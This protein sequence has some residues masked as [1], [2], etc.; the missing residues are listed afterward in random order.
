MITN[1]SN[2]DQTY[3]YGRVVSQSSSGGIFKLFFLLF[4]VVGF[5]LAT[6][7]TASEFLA[8]RVYQAGGGVILV[9]PLKKTSWQD[10]GVVPEPEVILPVKTLGGYVDQPFLFDSGAVISSLPREFAEKTG[11]D[12]AFLPRSTFKGFGGTTSFA[13]RGEMNLLLGEK[14]ATFPVVFTEAMGTKSLL[15]RKGFWDQ[16]S[17]Y[18]NHKEKRLEIRE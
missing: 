8:E 5:T 3:S 1:M 15:G 2:A 11:Q 4:I 18:F 17:V 7:L 6:A 16:F 9:A 10:L 14:E 13:Y 12:L